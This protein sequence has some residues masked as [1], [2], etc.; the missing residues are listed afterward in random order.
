MNNEEIIDSLK[1]IIRSSFIVELVSDGK[2]SL[3]SFSPSEVFD[4]WYKNIKYSCIETNDFIATLCLRA[5]QAGHICYPVDKN[6]TY[7]GVKS[8]LKDN[9][10]YKVL[11]SP[12]R[13]TSNLEE[14]IK[15]FIDEKKQS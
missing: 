11:F 13:C 6:Y 9:E 4:I 12:I 15:K 10:I 1:S 5:S 8:S 7:T 3:T 2:S 14:T